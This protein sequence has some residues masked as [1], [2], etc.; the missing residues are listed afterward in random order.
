M[1]QEKSN[2]NEELT[3]QILEGLQDS[4]FE[5][6][7]G[8]DYQGSELQKE[9]YKTLEEQDD[10][11]N[12]Y[13]TKNFG[14]YQN[15]LQ[16]KKIQTSINVFD[17]TVHYMMDVTVI[18]DEIA[19]K[20]DH[21]SPDQLIMEALSGICTVL[22]LDKDNNAKRLV[23]TLERKTIPTKELPTRASFFSPMSGDRIGL[24]DINKQGWRSFYMNKAFK[25]VRDDT[26]G[27]E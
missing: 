3:A 17:P 26:I 22:F 12:Q 25:F 27:L 2:F 10:N 5:R 24:W 21:I 11:Y 14:S 20:T 7:F 6:K 19:Y 1:A 15:F 16:Q 8:G 4:T 9:T 18:T 13:I 23:G